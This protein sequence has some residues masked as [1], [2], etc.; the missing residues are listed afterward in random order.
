MIAVAV[1][2]LNG[3]E[4]EVVRTLKKWGLTYSRDV[5]RV[6]LRTYNRISRTRMTGEV[7]WAPCDHPIHNM[8]QSSGILSIVFTIHN[9]LLISVL[10]TSPTVA[11]HQGN[12]HFGT[13][14]HLYY[15]IQPDNHCHNVSLFCTIIRQQH[16]EYNCTF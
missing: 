15:F 7:V 6:N 12:A 9:V 8:M 5:L 2:V 4:S 13:R 14:R 1:P 3:E 16:K 11:S 10:Y